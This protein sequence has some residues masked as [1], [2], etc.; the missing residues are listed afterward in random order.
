MANDDSKTTAQTSNPKRKRPRQMQWPNRRYGSAEAL[1][2]Y[3]QGLPM[4]EI[5]RRLRHCE[6]SIKDY[7]NHKQKVPWWIPEILRLQDLERRVIFRE[8]FGTSIKA[9]LHEIGTKPKGRVKPLPEI[10]PKPLH[11]DAEKPGEKAA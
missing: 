11:V 6:R 3:T 9:D 8:M 7:L 2:Y 4:Q 10:Q 1:M 5:C